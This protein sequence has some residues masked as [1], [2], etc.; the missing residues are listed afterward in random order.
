M[1]LEAAIRKSPRGAAQRRSR[2]GRLIVAMAV[3]G[4]LRIV[5]SLENPRIVG[6]AKDVDLDS[7]E[8]RPCK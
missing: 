2:K 8:W 6:L 1:K 3:K 7:N 5:V 4:T